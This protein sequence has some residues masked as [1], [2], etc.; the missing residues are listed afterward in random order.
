[1]RRI[2]MKELGMG[3][4]HCLFPP[5]LFFGV[6]A[7][8]LHFYLVESRAPQLFGFIFLFGLG[9]ASGLWPILRLREP[10]GVRTKLIRDKFTTSDAVHFPGSRA[11]EAMALLWV[12][13]FAT[14]I[15]GILGS[16]LPLNFTTKMTIGTALLALVF[17]LGVKLVAYGENGITVVPGGLYWKEIG[18]TT[19]YIPWEAIAEVGLFMKKEPNVR[20]VPTLGIN[21]AQPD[22]VQTSKAART[23]MIASRVRH[24]WHLYFFSETITVPLTLVEAFV[25][26][27]L[28]KPDA[29]LELGTS[30]GLERIRAM[31]MNL[32]LI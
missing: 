25:Q 24:G 18:R 32:Q 5:T 20:P 31:E 14:G 13:S 8:S 21:I 7:G 29:R 22:L 17:Y 4:L 27:Y 3:W 2:T 26:Y 15:F 11:K 30:A 10:Q 28:T 23:A 12:L 9:S 6:A 19:Y 16:A 1:M